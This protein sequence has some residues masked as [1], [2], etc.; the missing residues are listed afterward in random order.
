[1]QIFMGTTPVES[2]VAAGNIFVGQVSLSMEKNTKMRLLDLVC[3]HL[4]VKIILNS[5]EVRTVV[6]KVWWL[7]SW[8]TEFC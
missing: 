8:K 4:C 3:E 6:Q 1:M 2:L 5:Y 7:I